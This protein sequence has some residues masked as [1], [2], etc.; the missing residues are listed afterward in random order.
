MVFPPHKSNDT[1]IEIK[2]FDQFV[3][4][5]PNTKFLGLWIDSNLEWDKQF[6][7]PCTKLKQ[8]TGLLKRCKNLLTVSALRSV[9]FAHVHSHLS[10]SVFVWGSTSKPAILKK[11]QKLQNSCIKVMKA[12]LNLED[13]FV[14]LKI[15]TLNNLI[16]IEL[17]KFFYKL[18]NDLLPIKLMDRVF[19]NSKGR[20]LRKTHGYMTR[21]KHLPNLPTVQASQYKKSFLAHS[22]K[23]YTSL[24]DHVKKVP[25]LF[26]FVKKLKELL[27]N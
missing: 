4:I 25:T 14:N 12:D 15:P 13:G 26:S 3:P 24:P 7:V 27:Y 2:L 11:L 21:Q 19:S 8:N 6:S 18:L 16:V 5:R 1:K 20:D 10:Y 23:L 22:N 17:C 9:Y